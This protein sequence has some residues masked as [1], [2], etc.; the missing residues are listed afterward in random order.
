[1]K[2]NTLTK[3][4]AVLPFVNMSSSKDNE[5]FSDGM[6]EE[7]I[8]ALA[9]IKSLKVT[10][11]TSSFFFKNKNIPVA[12]IG[13]ELSVSTILEGSIRLSGKMMRITAQL[14]DVADD[15]HFW[16]E[17]FDRYTED[18]FAVQDEVSLLIADKLREHVG[19][20]DIEDHLV[21][22][23]ETPVEVYKNYLKGRYHLMKLNLTGTEKGISIFQEVIAAQP[24]FALAHL[25]IN[26]GYAYLGTMGKLPAAEAFAKAKPFLDKALELDENL[27][28]SQLNL[29]WISCWQNWDLKKAY[30]HIN[31]AIEIRPSDEIYLTMSNFLTLEGKF[32]AAHNYLNKALQLDPFSG[33]NNHYK[34]F[35]YYLE[36]KYE[37]AIPHF[38]KAL[39]LKPDLP[40]PDLYIGL[41]WILM[42]QSAKGLAFFQNLPDDERGELTKLGGTTLAYVALGDTPKLNECIAQL[43]AAMQTDSMGRAM[44][45]LIFTYTMMEKQKAAIKLIEQGMEYRMPLM[46]LL[47]TEPILKPLRSN[48]RFQELMQHIFGKKPIQEPVKKKYKNPSLSP[49]DSDRYH[50]RLEQYML[51]ENPFLQASLTL[52]E[53]AQMIDIHPNYLSELL[54]DRLGKN[55]SEFINHYRV[56]TFKALARDPKNAH[57][58]LL[59]LAF[60]SGF[61]SKT[62]FN[63]F[64]KKETGMTPKQFLKDIL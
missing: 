47:K 37:Q 58:S 43:E 50:T 54:N 19:H 29:A 16:S 31:K 39:R 15:F 57:L 35:L 21:E 41:S 38:E 9:K 62:S 11:R 6:T 2:Q 55:F 12:Q 48:T 53:L 56:E 28:E 61:N 52:R 60:E 40:F 45:Y 51:T 10:S 13:E 64:F 63:T 18:V 44:N 1:L 7:I 27:P 20:F 36:E 24:D 8:N 22:D 42:G 46:L 5:Y 32:E 3:T 17:T 14:I 23:L 34:G 49:E 33:M 59:G 30:Q 26:Q 25:A 4:I